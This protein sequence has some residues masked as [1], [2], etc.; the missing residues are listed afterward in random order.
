MDKSFVTKIREQVGT[1][2]I[3]LM[4]RET[5]WERGWYEEIGYQLHGIP[6]RGSND[7]PCYWRRRTEYNFGYLQRH[8]TNS[9]RDQMH[10]TSNKDWTCSGVMRRNQ[11]YF[12][13]LKIKDWV[14]FWIKTDLKYYRFMMLSYKA[15]PPLH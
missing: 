8:E 6:S 9:I 4:L 11:S 5:A 7:R 10:S 14:W 13:C 1:S 3:E 12:T 2:N 15:A